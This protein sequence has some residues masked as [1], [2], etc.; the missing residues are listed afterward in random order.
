MLYVER[1]AEFELD[2]PDASAEQKLHRVVELLK[3][4]TQEHNRLLTN[5]HTPP[6]T[7]AH[8]HDRSMEREL[9]IALH[10]LSHI[11]DENGKMRMA[12]L[13]SPVERLAEQ[14]KTFDD[15]PEIEGQ[16]L[17]GSI[18]CADF[19]EDDEEE[20]KYKQ[21]IE[22]QEEIL[23]KY[24]LTGIEKVLINFHLPEPDDDNFYP[25]VMIEED[26]PTIA[27]HMK[28]NRWIDCS[29]EELSGMVGWWYNL[30]VEL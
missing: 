21:I 14:G 6:F 10:R 30:P 26:K 28:D 7:R 17:S 19:D 2:N 29:G 4:A 9:E 22:T 11:D 23:S 15:L 20:E 12:A 13:K 27:R 8:E 5:Y 3:Q 16:E 25:V 18:D 1:Y 24:D